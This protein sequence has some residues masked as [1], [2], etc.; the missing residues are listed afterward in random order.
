MAIESFRAKLKEYLRLGGY[1]QKQLAAALQIHPAQFSNKLNAQ[2]YGNLTYPEVKQIVKVLAGWG[3]LTSQKQAL[4]LLDLMG[5]NYASFSPQ[6]WHQPPLADL[7]P[8]AKGQTSGPQQWLELD[9]EPARPP[10]K[11]P[12]LD[13]FQSFPP[14]LRTGPTHPTQPSSNTR[15]G[16]PSQDQLLAVLPIPLHLSRRRENWQGSIETGPFYNR[17][18][19]L[20]TLKQWVL[21]EKHRVVAVLGMG[22]MGKTT[23]TV[24]LVHQLKARFDFVIWHSLYNAPPLEI[25]LNDILQFL[26]GSDPLE[27]SVGIEA[28]LRRL[29]AILQEVSVLL[30]LDNWETI[31]QGGTLAGHYRPSYEEYG[32]LIE[33]IGQ[34][35][36]QSCLLLTSREKPLELG[37][38]EAK[39][40]KV[41]SLSLA[42]LAPEEAQPILQDLGLVGNAESQ[43]ALVERYCGNPLALKLVAAPVQTVFGGKVEAFLAEDWTIFGEIE[44]VLA[45]Q[46]KRLSEL[47]QHLVYWLAVA[48]E[49]L[50]L[51]EL[52]QNL[53]LTS[54]S[55]QVAEA[56]I[57]LAR[58]NL[59]ERE[60]NQPRFSLQPVVL[61]YLT[62]QLVEQAVE[63]LIRGQLQLVQTYALLQ[64][65]AKDYVKASQHRLILRPILERLLSHFSTKASLEAHLT[66]LLPKIREQP[67]ERQGY[68]GGNLIN[69]LRFLKGNLS[70][71]DFSELRVWQADL[72]G[73]ELQEVNFTR[74]DLERSSFTQ[75]FDSIAAVAFGPEGRL[76]AG[77]CYNG[78]VR[79]WEVTS[80]QLVLE[81]AGHNASVWSVAF[82]PDGA[83]LVSSSADHTIRVWDVASGICLKTLQG[84]TNAVWSIAFSPDGRF[85]ASGS[86]DQTI[87][88]WEVA[89]NQ[90]VKILP[91]SGSEIRSVAFSPDG[92]SLISGSTN[93]LVKVWDIASG[94][95]LSTLQG[96]SNMVISVAFSSDGRTVA[97]G[98]TDQ[99]VKVWDVTNGEC[100]STLQ[101]HTNWIMSVAFSPDGRTVASGGADQTI[102][103]WEVASG[104]CLKTLQGHS[105]MVYSVAFSPDGGSLVS[106]S[107]DQ[108]IKLWEVASGEC[109]KTWQGYIN[110]IWSVAFSSDG[111]TLAGGSADQ[112]IKLWDIPSGKYLKVLQGHSLEVRSVA[113]NPT[114][115]ILASGGFDQ[116]IKLWEVDRGECLKTLRGHSN[117]VF[118]VAFSPDGAILASGGADQTVKVWE[119]ASGQCFQT[120]R[121]HSNTI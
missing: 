94:E 112:T 32:K 43:K 6:E 121:G 26:V 9:L 21:E 84:H 2:N 67:F 120:L 114:D 70:G 73:V 10:H 119:V 89:S 31:L 101:G 5:L 77:G 37:L 19:E 105:N 23:L 60:H 45:Q 57:S 78:V 115:R 61:E 55:K 46:L 27:L 14:V 22:G 40:N 74:C 42:G 118:S 110:L 102:R 113:F 72:Q 65:E 54:S 41:C 107:S 76:V 66:Q 3:V 90:C 36:H 39:M 35:N 68:S 92:H 1:S 44:Q 25:L 8:L 4:E 85:V 34:T 80:G 109:L 11:L 47:E 88:L 53:I 62:E 56:L 103:L 17:Q 24:Q 71:Y 83:S 38:L 100:L 50:S 58:R 13:S 97:S 63:E 69:L 12:Q 18:K 106:G 79:V 108:T 95:C 75:A 116:T 59:L 33:L 29:L 91:V 48:R 7:E 98:S 28:K 64:A 111:R 99:T 52:E 51:A 20:L 86:A 87:R 49:P 82:S 93:Q 15:N 96:H 117:M 81:C 16:S 30:V 104:K